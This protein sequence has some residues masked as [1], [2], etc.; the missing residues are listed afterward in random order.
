MGILNLRFLDNMEAGTP[1]DRKIPIAYEGTRFGKDGDIRSGSI[2][3]KS[4]DGGEDREISTQALGPWNKLVKFLKKINTAMA[5]FEESNY[6]ALF[7]LSS[8]D[9][10]LTLKDGNGSLES[11]GMSDLDE[12]YNRKAEIADGFAAAPDGSWEEEWKI[13][14]RMY[15]PRLMNWRPTMVLH[16]I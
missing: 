14:L 2:I 4:R 15:I 11:F 10:V 5:K 16:W 9:F 7:D 1:L 12:Y 13:D 8:L 3:V 6:A